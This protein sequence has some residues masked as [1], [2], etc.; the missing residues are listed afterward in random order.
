VRLAKNCGADIDVTQ[1][2]LLESEAGAATEGRGTEIVIGVPVFS[3][4]FVPEAEL[5][6]SARGRGGAGKVSP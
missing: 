2:D 4:L 1:W 3:S 6:H 5:L